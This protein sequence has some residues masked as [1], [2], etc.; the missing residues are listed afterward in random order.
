VLW[1]LATPTDFT[2]EALGQLRQ[3]HNFQWYAIPLL[4]FVF[5]AYSVEVG[6]GRWD[7]VGAGLAVW[8]ADGFNEIVN[9]VIL[10]ASG[11]AALWTETGPTAY[12]FTVGLNLETMFMFAVAGIVFAR[13]L[14]ADRGARVLGIPNRF[15]FALGLSIFSVAV[16]V[17]LHATGRFHWHYWFWGLKSLPVI[18]IFGYLWFYMYAAWVHDSPP[19]RRWILLGALAAINASMILVFGVI[20]GWL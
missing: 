17:F 8:L 7:I 2:R 9:A 19:A 5:Y 13:T 10:H 11:T 1:L 4:A 15:A 16:E 20:L 12:Q 3:A 18:V 14:P 6:R